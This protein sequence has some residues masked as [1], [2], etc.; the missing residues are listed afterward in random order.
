M[1]QVWVIAG[2]VCVD[3]VCATVV[4]LKTDYKARFCSGYVHGVSVG[5][6]GE[7]YMQEAAVLHAFRVLREW[8]SPIDQ[9]LLQHVNMLAGSALV[10]YQIREWLTHGKCTLQSAA[11]PGLVNDLQRL[12]E[13]LQTDLSYRPFRLPD[14]PTDEDTYITQHQ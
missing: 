11:A 7:V 10:H 14:D 5:E 8:L 6:S 3:E 4:I 12:G 1:T 9:T 2:V 13:W